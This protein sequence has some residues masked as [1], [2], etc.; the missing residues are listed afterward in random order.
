MAVSFFLEILPPNASGYYLN[1]SVRKELSQY[2]MGLVEVERIQ[3]DLS[4]SRREVVTDHLLMEDVVVTMMFE[5]VVLALRID[6]L[7][8]VS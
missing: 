3:R 6:V 2:L 4:H 1:Q 7:V 8:V 5:C